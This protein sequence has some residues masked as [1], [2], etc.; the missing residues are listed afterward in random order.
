MAYRYKLSELAKK[1]SADEAEKELGIP[2]SRFEVGQVTYSD[3]GTS[4]SE[5]TDIDPETGAVKWEITQLPGFDLLYDE[6]DDLVDIS[7][8][9]YIKTKDDKKFREFYDEIRKLRNS[10]RTHL[11]NEYPDQYKR[12]TR[13][14]EMYS[15]GILDLDKEEK[16]KEGTC[17]YGE[18]GVVGDTPAGPDLIKEFVGGQL[19]KRSDVLFNQLVPSSGAAETVEG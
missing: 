2:K 7:K 11:R 16:V 12:I 1:A 17:G 15:K 3:D 9:V 8:R 13:I 10:I 14:G 6:I 18:D 19:E 4:K 5:I